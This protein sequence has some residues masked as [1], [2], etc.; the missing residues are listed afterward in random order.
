MFE[1][2][3][4]GNQPPI[5]TKPLQLPH[6]REGVNEWAK[7][8][9]PLTRFLCTRRGQAAVWEY[10]A[11]ASG[12]RG[13]FICYLP[14]EKSI[15]RG[16]GCYTLDTCW[17]LFSHLYIIYS[18]LSKEFVIFFFMWPDPRKCPPIYSQRFSSL[19]TLRII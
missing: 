7:I 16:R 2:R 15:C 12:L 1:L 6:P 17:E 10:S 4:R 13:K 19:S 18:P 9:M 11:V 3:V 8:V 14:G 5:T